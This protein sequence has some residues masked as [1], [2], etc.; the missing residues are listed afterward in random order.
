[1]RP[2]AAWICSGGIQGQDPATH[3]PALLEML[4]L[5]YVGSTPLA[6]GLADN[7]AKAKALVRNAGITTPDF[8]V[9]PAGG[10]PSPTITSDYPVMVKPVCGMCSCGVFRADSFPE[11]SR[12]VAALQREYHSDVLVERFVAGIAAPAPAILRTQG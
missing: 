4:G 8:R 5:A 12:G 3:L 2:D 10:T 9:V 6:A 11:L 7:K 1:M